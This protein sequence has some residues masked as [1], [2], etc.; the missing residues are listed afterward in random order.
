M[1]MKVA[2]KPFGAGAFELPEQTGGAPL[3]G[4]WPCPVIDPEAARS[5]AEDLYP[6]EVLA[7]DVAADLIGLLSGDGMWV[8]AG[9]VSF[10]PVRPASENE[11]NCVRRLV[12]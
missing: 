12:E 6:G 11:D 7:V 3:G 8:G 4:K 10:L 9:G 2:I 5:R 1:K